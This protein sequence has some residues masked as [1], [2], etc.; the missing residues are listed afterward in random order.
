MNVKEEDSY[1]RQSGCEEVLN[2]IMPAAGR[3]KLRGVLCSCANRM[4]LT[5]KAPN[6]VGPS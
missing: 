2:V 5:T 1:Y 6:R 3:G 4:V